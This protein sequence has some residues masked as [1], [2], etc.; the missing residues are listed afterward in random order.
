MNVIT[1]AKRHQRARELLI[2]DYTDLRA[3]KYVAA[4][5]TYYD[6]RRTPLKLVSTAVTLA[7]VAVGAC[8][9]LTFG[10]TNGTFTLAI[11]GVLAVGAANAHINWNRTPAA[12]YKRIRATV[13]AAQGI[14]DSARPGPA[15]PSAERISDAVRSG[16]LPLLPPGAL[17]GYAI[18]TGGVLGTPPVVPRAVVDIETTRPRSYEPEQR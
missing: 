2:S 1:A 11:L 4:A 13:A 12:D 18:G 16:A 17:P 10:M 8:F 14:A 15:A 5:T 9:L 3:S 6:T 7:A